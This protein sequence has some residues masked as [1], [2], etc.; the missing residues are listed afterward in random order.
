MIFRFEGFCCYIAPLVLL[1]LLW[2]L[3]FV[4]LFSFLRKNLK[5]GGLDV[6]VDVL[7]KLGQDLDGFLPLLLILL[8]SK[9]SSFTLL[10]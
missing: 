3:F 4:C 1:L 9:C 7:A 2:F 10:L 6:R 5:L 8:I